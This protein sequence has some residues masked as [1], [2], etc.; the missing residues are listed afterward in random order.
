MS[1]WIAQL[2]APTPLASAVSSLLLLAILA[3]IYAGIRAVRRKPKS[4]G[5]KS[6]FTRVMD[7]LRVTGRTV[8]KAASWATGTRYRTRARRIPVL[9][10]FFLA[11]TAGAVF[12]PW[13]WG[14]VPIILGVLGILIVFLHWSIDEDEAEEQV[15]ADRKMLPILG[16]LHIEVKIAVGFLLVLAPIAFSLLQEHGYGFRMTP[17]AGPFTFLVFTLIETLKA[18]SLVD[19]YDLW[20]DRLGFDQITGVRAPQTWAKWVIIGYRL[21]LNLLILAALK[22]LIDIYRRRAEG[23]DLRPVEAMLRE[24]DDDL[25]EVAVDQLNDFALRGRG[26]ARDLL[27]R[28]LQPAPTDTWQ[29]GPLQRARAANALV[30]YADRQGVSRD[31]PCCWLA[32][33]VGP[34]KL[35]GLAA[36][37]LPLRH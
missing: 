28:I 16:D 21:S 15:P 37:F 14:F 31:R 9:L 27:E 35:R 12:A 18:G 8:L 24:H 34:G 2:N 7:G 11:M 23:Y 1:Q 26:N 4:P 22:R 13:P 17:N 5:T 30:A 33:P 25:H 29:V 3:V 20:A 32:A 19:Y 36:S 6:A 10:T